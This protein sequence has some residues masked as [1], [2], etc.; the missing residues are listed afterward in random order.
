MSI[1]FS[2][3]QSLH[4]ILLAVK[5]ALHVSLRVT[6]LINENL[7]LEP[8]KEEAKKSTIII[9]KKSLASSWK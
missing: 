8:A 7:P 9:T 1:I 4:G 3:Y 2:P 5:V 6:L